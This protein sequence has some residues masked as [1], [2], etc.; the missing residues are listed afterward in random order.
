MGDSRYIALMA[1]GPQLIAIADSSLLELPI[2]MR[3]S[4]IALSAL[5][6]TAC[7]GANTGGVAAAPQ[8]TKGS[9]NLITQDEIT[10][11]RF[12][13]ALE[14]VQSLRPAMLRPRAATLTTANGSLGSMSNGA[15]SVS[16]IVFLDQAR[17]GESNTLA[18]IAASSVKEIRFISAADATTLW[19]TGYSA[20]VIQ[21][22]TRSR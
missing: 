15:S 8:P 3:F 20:G 11:G 12:S 19:G 4:V 5:L 13:N 21:V 9:A 6:V 18:T 22:I 14:I 17:Y 10:G 2:P 16:I 1:P 7:S